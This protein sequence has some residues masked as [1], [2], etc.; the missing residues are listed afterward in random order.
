MCDSKGTCVDLYLK[1]A[2]EGAVIKW[3]TQIDE[4]LKEDS[5]CAFVKESNPTPRFGMYMC[6]DF[7]PGTTF[8]CGPG[9]VVGIATGYGLDG[10]GIESRWGRNFPH[11]SRPAL[12]PTQPPVQW[13]LGLS[14]G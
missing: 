11:L 9:S 6:S 3:A 7:S 4:V 5:S 13:V 14:R 1:S 8:T 12:G 10:S 2:I